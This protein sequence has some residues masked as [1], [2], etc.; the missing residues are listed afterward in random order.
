MDIIENEY[1]KAE[2]QVDHPFINYLMYEV[3]CLRC[4]FTEY[5][6]EKDSLWMIGLNEKKSLPKVLSQLHEFIRGKVEGGEKFLPID[7]SQISENK[8]VRQSGFDIKK[9]EFEIDQSWVGLDNQELSEMGQLIY[10][11]FNF[12]VFSKKKHNFRCDK[13]LKHSC[14]APPR[15]S[16]RILCN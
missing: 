8:N 2:M 6:V 12:S 3:K 16:H 7:N 4:K 9:D 10:I 15:K 5:F 14:M 11:Y 1:K 13:C